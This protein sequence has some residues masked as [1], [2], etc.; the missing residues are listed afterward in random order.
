MALSRLPVLERAFGAL[1]NKTGWRR[2][3]QECFLSTEEMA[4][5]FTSFPSPNSQK[6]KLA[7]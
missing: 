1:P 2:K 6:H 7:P 3:H 5:P 4:E